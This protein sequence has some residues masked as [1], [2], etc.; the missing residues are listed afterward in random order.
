MIV[1][2]RY[3]AMFF[4]WYLL[5]I[6]L[7]LVRSPHGTFFPFDDE[8]LCFVCVSLYSPVLGPCSECL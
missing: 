8:Q 3:L 6:K 7:N 1:M 2:P 4:C 5:A